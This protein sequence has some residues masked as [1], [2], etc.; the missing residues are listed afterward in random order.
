MSMVMSGHKPKHMPQHKLCRAQER[1]GAET[2]SPQGM[3]PPPSDPRYNHLSRMP[4]LQQEPPGSST[5][6]S[7]AAEQGSATRRSVYDR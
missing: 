7:S 5:A 2:A 6:A 4:A 1:Q 3:T